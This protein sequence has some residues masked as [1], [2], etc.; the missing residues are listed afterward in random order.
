MGL[1]QLNFGGRNK[2]EVAVDN[3]KYYEPPEGYYLGFSGGKDSVVIYDLAEKA[4][5]RFDAHYNVSPIDPPEI[6]HFIKEEYPD[7][8][9]DKLARNFWKRMMT[10]SPPMRTSR[11]C[12]ELIKEAGGIGRIKLLGMRQKE[13]V[14]RKDYCLIEKHRKYPNT[15]WMLPIVTWDNPEVWE[16]IKLNNLRYCSL[17]NEGYTRLGCVL[18][19]FESPAATQKNINR[20]PRIANNWKRAFERYYQI[21]IDRGTP[22]PYDSAQEFWEWWISRK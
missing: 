18:C 11:W 16:Y 7:V 9:W 6:Y 21:R 12:C 14:S 17:Y 10:E 20:F 22:L 3:L 19:P 4:K 15:S 2:I 13:S 5:V 1:M 8:A